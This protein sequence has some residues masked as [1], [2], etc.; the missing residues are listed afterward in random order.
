MAME[1]P[2]DMAGSSLRR[3]SLHCSLSCSDTSR[4][5]FES[6]V[7][8]AGKAALRLPRLQVMEIWGVCVDGLNSH[9][10]IFQYIN[11]DHRASIV[12]RSSR[13]TPAIEKNIMARWSQ[14]AQKHSR[15]TLASAIVPIAVTG[16]DIS[17][18]A[19]T[20]IY[21]HLLLKDLI[22]DPVSRMLLEHDSTTSYSFPFMDS[23]EPN[24]DIASLQEESIHHEARVTSFL[25]LHCQDPVLAKEA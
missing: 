9:A 12:W 16:R 3:L 23:S 20:C 17:K 5:V 7:R 13:K 15:T 2:K 10:Y 6:L 11:E 18:S 24:P 8:L 4:E 14:V 22:F 1:S 19:G 25:K 21:R